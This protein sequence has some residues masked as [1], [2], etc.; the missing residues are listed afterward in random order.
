MDKQGLRQ[1]IL[2]KLRER[3]MGVFELSV[4]LDESPQTILEALG[5]LKNEE[6]VNEV[7]FQ[8]VYWRIE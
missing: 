2:A 5:E 3:P 7:P 4:E 1:V 8:T 6:R